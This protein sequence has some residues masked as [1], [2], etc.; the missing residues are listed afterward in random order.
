MKVNLDSTL[1]ILKLFSDS[2]CKNII[3]G[4]VQITTELFLHIKNASSLTGVGPEIWRLMLCVLK[5]KK[6]PKPT[7]VLINL[8]TNCW[9]GSKVEG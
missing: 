7:V 1:G 9:S 2:G 6:K 8:I 4:K 5:K 3:V